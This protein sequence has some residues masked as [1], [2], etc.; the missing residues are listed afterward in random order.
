MARQRLRSMLALVAL[1]AAAAAISACGEGDSSSDSSDAASSSTSTSTD[2]EQPTKVP[3][4]F[5]RPRTRQDQLG[6]FLMKA[7]KTS[8]VVNS[9][10]QGFDLPPG[11]KVDLVNGLG[12]GPFYN[13]KSNSI[14]F[15]YG[16]AALIYNTIRQAHPDWTDFQIGKAGGAVNSFILAHEFTHALIANF[17]LPVLG[18][19]EDAADALAGLILLRAQGGNQLLL[20]TADFWAQFSQRQAT[21]TLSAYADTHSLDLQRAFSMACD[22][23]GS[24]KKG[25]I[26]VARL[27]LLPRSRLQGCLA[28]YQQQVDSFEQV[29]EPHTDGPLNLGG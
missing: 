13:P 11:L 16:F 1:V 20:D 23:A 27:G 5:Q 2:A 8:L 19:E 9:F 7:G 17:D 12:G 10:A 22:V 3:V 15:Q 21:P 18:R 26:T 4:A 14:T 25:F 24:S 29:L 28:E 6:A